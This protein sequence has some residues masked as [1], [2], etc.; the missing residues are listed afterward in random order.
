M[1]VAQGGSQEALATLRALL[2]SNLGGSRL[3]PRTDCPLVISSLLGWPEA[4]LR[5]AEA[6]PREARAWRAWAV[7]G[8]SPAA[9]V[10]GA[11]GGRLRREEV[12]APG[13]A[14]A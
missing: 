5:R 3:L 11:V 7:G 10:L 6:L 14:L 2:C 4:V 9:R 12:L 1:E 8:A 13:G